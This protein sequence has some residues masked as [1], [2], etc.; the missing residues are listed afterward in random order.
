M[1]G[2]M[3]GAATLKESVLLSPLNAAPPPVLHC[4]GRKP[5]PELDVR[6]PLSGT[7]NPPAYAM[8]G[9]DLFHPGPLQAPR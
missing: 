5:S 1:G 4:E 9:R 8:R 6:A 3:E 2:P 7:P